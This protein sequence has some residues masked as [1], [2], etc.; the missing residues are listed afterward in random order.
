MPSR[1]SNASRSAGQRSR[2]SALRNSTA[3]T[4]HWLACGRAGG[5]A[6][7]PW[8]PGG[9]AWRE[10]ASQ[11]GRKQLKGWP[12]PVLAQ[13]AH[14][15]GRQRAHQAQRAQQLIQAPLHLAASCGGLQPRTHGRQRRR[16]AA[17][18]RSQHLWRGGRRQGELGVGARGQKLRCSSGAAM[19]AA[20]SG[21]VD[22]APGSSA[23]LPKP[24]IHPSVAEQ[25]KRHMP[26]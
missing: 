16:Q 18:Q 26:E 24:P 14:L 21:G 10:C 23:G 3:T 11:P 15:E 8:E 5:S 2:D 12:Q 6:C 7:A 17:A 4:C 22:P 20:I 25:T 19:P 9:H 13:L 1:V